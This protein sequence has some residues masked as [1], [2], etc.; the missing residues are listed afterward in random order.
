MSV[1]TGGR[2]AASNARSKP[3]R[4][5]TRP[6][7]K[8]RRARVNPGGGLFAAERQAKPAHDHE[9]AYFDEESPKGK[10]NE[11]DVILA[12]EGVFHA[13]EALKALNESLY[14]AGRGKS[15]GCLKLYCLLDLIDRELFSAL[16]LLR[17]YSP[18][19]PADN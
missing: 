12:A 9:A 17:P 1:E 6:A 4:N 2:R 3:S 18:F 16:D 19:I 14:Q 7:P 15:I 8:K 11:R 10:L 5:P 13:H